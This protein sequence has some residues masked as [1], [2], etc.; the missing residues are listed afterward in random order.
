MHAVE[1][2]RFTDGPCKYLYFFLNWSYIYEG[3]RRKET[4]YQK[5][6]SYTNEVNSCKSFWAVPFSWEKRSHARKLNNIFKIN[7]FIYIKLKVAVH[8]FWK[9]APCSINDNNSLSLHAMSYKHC[10]QWQYLCKNPDQ[11]KKLDFHHRAVQGVTSN[12]S[13]IF[14]LQSINP[15]LE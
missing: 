10:T 3:K 7:I 2:E 12:L 11:T 1:R 4:S 13:W 15:I 14:G 6:G 8:I 5:E 9:N